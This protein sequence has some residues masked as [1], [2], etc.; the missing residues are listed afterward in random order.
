MLPNDGSKTSYPNAPSPR[1]ADAI[2]LAALPGYEVFALTDE[3]GQIFEMFPPDGIIADGPGR[4]LM[5]NP[6]PDMVHPEDLS[7]IEASWERLLSKPYNT[8][9]IL[10]RFRDGSNEW[11]WTECNGINLLS[12]A[13]IDAVFVQYRPV[14][15]EAVNYSRLKSSEMFLRGILD[16]IDIG[17]VS[18]TPDRMIEYANPVAEKTFGLS[19][20]EMVG[21]P[22]EDLRW[23]YFTPDGEPWSLDELPA[24]RQTEDASPFNDAVL[25]I[26]FRPD[27]AIRFVRYSAVAERGVMNQLVRWI[28][29]FRDITDEW[30]SGVAR[31]A[32]QERLA[33]ATGSNLDGLFDW[34]VVNDDVWWNQQLANIFAYAGEGNVRQEIF[35]KI[36]DPESNQT[37]VDVLY[38]P[39]PDSEVI[40]IEVPARRLDGEEIWIRIQ[41]KRQRDA[42]GQ[43]VRVAGSVTDITERKRAEFAAREADENLSMALDAGDVT[44]FD[45]DT[46][47]DW[48]MLRGP[49]LEKLFGPGAEP[50]QKREEWARRIHPQD[51]PR[52]RQAYATYLADPSN[53]ID[54]AQRMIAH[55]GQEL[56]VQVNGRI[57]RDPC[58]A[59][60]RMLGTCT[61]RTAY[62]AE[63][64]RAEDLA[65]RLRQALAHG[66]VGV[67]Q[68]DWAKRRIS[69]SG[70]LFEDLFGDPLPVDSDLDEFLAHIDPASWSEA[71]ARSDAA[72]AARSPSVEYEIRIMGTT[73][74]EAT[75]R[76]FVQFDYL[77]DG[78]LD[79]SLAVTIDITAQKQEERRAQRFQEHLELA[80]QQGSV[81][82]WIFDLLR[83]RV[84]LLGKLFEDLLGFPLVE[85]LEGGE[86]MAIIKPED[87]EAARAEIERAIESRRTALE[88]DVHFRGHDGRELIG[89]SFANI[90]YLPDGTPFRIRGATVDITRQVL[91]EAES[92]A[93]NEQLEQRVADRTRELQEANRQLESFTY[94]VS[95]DL[96][97]P[98]RAI[99][100]YATMLSRDYGDVLQGEALDFLDG[101]IT[102]SQYMGVLIEDLL[103]FSRL[104]RQALQ[105]EVFAPHVVIENVLRKLESAI[106][107]KNIQIR[108]G[109]LPDVDGDRRLLQIVFQ[110]L[111]E[112][113]IKFA[114]PGEVPIVEVGAESG[115]DGPVFYVRDNGIGFEPN[116]ADRIFRVFERLHA[117]QDIPGTGVGLAIVRRIVV[118]HGGT[119]WAEGSP[120]QGACFR[121]RLGKRPEEP[122]ADLTERIALG[123]R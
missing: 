105:W 33:Y 30:R 62:R 100:G 77:P 93:L 106:E 85:E 114:R 86:S 80:L 58:G 18:A 64:E 67:W 111:I 74:K 113:A 47:D 20:A 44:L 71:Q 61:D 53:R 22:L 122:P 15:G 16:T 81:G 8:Q 108:I 32:G 5:D 46:N 91:A 35:G 101:I 121:F 123:Q 102:A 117:S 21:K 48:I 6:T 2:R 72:V 42:Q 50:Y 40:A 59:P 3:R 31:R 45:V 13:G 11:S 104:G 99:N 95:H 19:S 120:G 84:T 73:G 75:C 4:R 12:H 38:G 87:R 39:T 9:T 65:G 56:F 36:F 68:V 107:Q 115:P 17:V 109:A 66:A 25:G 83:D 55:D 96:R 70:K 98:L 116:Q 88:Y 82:I 76:A 69:L 110:N 90:D 103:Q 37:V 29:T 14:G 79:R 54:I 118:M 57:D 51:L 7:W 34:D 26:R 49:L 63:Q 60:I 24:W 28:F 119:V 94:S 89:R 10:L 1:L 52:S 43:L 78:T 97:G 23:E 112:N 41:A 27:S 92:R